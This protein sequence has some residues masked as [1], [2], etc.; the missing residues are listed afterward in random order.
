MLNTLKFRLVNGL[1][2]DPAVYL[3]LNQS[4]DCVLFD[5]GA[6]ENLTN[7]ELLRIRLIAI[8]HTHVD[9]FVGFDRLIRVN[10]PHFRTLEII[11]PAGIT[12]NLMSKLKA[13]TWNLLEN[14]QMNFIVHEISPSGLPT[15][16]QLTNDNDFEPIPL[17]IYPDH[18]DKQEMVPTTV[19]LTTVPKIKLQAVVVDHGTPVLAFYLEMPSSYVVSKNALNHLNL[20][21]GPWISQLQKLA[22]SNDLRGSMM[23][24]GT[25]WN[26]SELASRILVARPGERLMYVTDM[27]F[28]SN[29]LAK[30][31]V[32]SSGGVDLLIC[33]SNFLQRD[34]DK[35]QKK[36]HLTSYQAA[37]IATVLNAKILQVFHVSNIYAEN[38][39][40]AEEEASQSLASLK[41]CDPQELQL[42]LSREY[43]QSPQLSVSLVT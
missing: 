18:G 3:Q 28:S 40:A 6:L 8:S 38:L 41:L 24:D 23:I 31:K 13:Y 11:G 42:R 36:S 9:H 29:N 5:A 4:S 35:A 10:I 16:F 2:G 12:F 34:R 26:M 33:E 30:L 32:L 22:G 27:S 20:R 14:G 37:L 17:Q 39:G 15:A 25:S 43:A 1:G 7:R 19:L 21:P